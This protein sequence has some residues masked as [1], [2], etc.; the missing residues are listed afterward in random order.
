[1]FGGIA[2]V[3]IAQTGFV[4]TVA[5]MATDIIKGTC[6]PWG[7]YRSIAAQK[8]TTAFLFTLGLMIPLTIM[9]FCYSRIIYKLTH[10]VTAHHSVCLKSILPIHFLSVAVTFLLQFF[11]TK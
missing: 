5:F 3:W 6:V 4:M 11:A 10:K 1:V 8:T 9:L 2:F 7:A